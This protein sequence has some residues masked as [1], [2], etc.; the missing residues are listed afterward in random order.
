MGGGSMGGGG[1]GNPFSNFGNPN[2]PGSPLLEAFTGQANPWSQL[3][4]IGNPTSNANH[5]TGSGNGGSFGGGS[6]I[7]PQSP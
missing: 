3:S 6:S 5:S 4:G 7:T 1:G 2:G